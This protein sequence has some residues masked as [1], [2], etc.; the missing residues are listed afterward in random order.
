MSKN[1]RFASPLQ[2]LTIP[3]PEFRRMLET[4]RTKFLPKFLTGLTAENHIREEIAVGTVKISDY[5][6]DNDDD[7]FDVS[8]QD[9]VGNTKTAE[10]KRKRREDTV[11]EDAYDTAIASFEQQQEQQRLSSKKMKKKKMTNSNKYQYVGVVGINNNKDKKEKKMNSP[12]I[13]WY[14]RPKPKHSNWSVRLLH[15]NKDVIIKDLF[16]QGKIDIFAKYTN[17]GQTMQSL[18]APVVTTKYEARERSWK[19]L[20]NFSPKHFFT[21]SSGAYW[22]ER[23]LRA[24]MYTDGDN[25]YESSYRYRDGRNGMNRVSTFQQFLSSKSVDA[26]EKQRILKKLQS[27]APDIV[28]EM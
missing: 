4:P 26:K 21:D 27:A 7:S 14:A 16:D 22:R 19:T 25:V 18:Q 24:G 15:V 5:S 13:S 11:V 10:A 17:T 9:W 28:L 20:W 6:N 2:S 23:R 3:D 1:I 8:G 12:P